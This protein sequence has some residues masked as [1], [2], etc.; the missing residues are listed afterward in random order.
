MNNDLELFAKKLKI[1]RQKRRLTLE[2]LA[3]LA[4]LTPNHIAKLEATKSHPSFNAISR[5][6][7]ALDV[8]LKDLF[9]FED[10]KSKNYIKEEFAKILDKSDTS[11][12]QLLYRIHKSITD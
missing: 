3:E 10:L 5:L 8:E 4:D 1:L 2:K 9:D 11:H 7:Q 12:L 6:A